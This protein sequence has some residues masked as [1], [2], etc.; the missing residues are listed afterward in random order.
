MRRTNR[1]R[2]MNGSLVLLRFCASVAPMCVTKLT[3]A[4][5]CGFIDP[6]PVCG[7]TERSQYRVLRG[8]PRGA[9]R[10]VDRDRAGRNAL[11]VKVLSL[12][13]NLIYVVAEQVWSS[14]GSIGSGNRSGTTGVLGRG[15]YGRWTLERKRSVRNRRQS[16]EPGD[17]TAGQG[18]TTKSGSTFHAEVR[19]F[20]SSE[21]VG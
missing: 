20:H 1:H 21:E 15:M 19:S 4:S 6:S 18:V 13:K 14:E 5:R 16:S 7:N 3:S 17:V 8:S 12:D 2:A 9:L 10:S 11:S